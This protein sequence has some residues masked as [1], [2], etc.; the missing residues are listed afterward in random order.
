MGYF[1][2]H[3][4][5]CDIEIDFFGESD[6]CDTCRPFSKAY[7]ELKEKHHSI[8]FEDMC[9]KDFMTLMLH[10]VLAGEPLTEENK[11]NWIKLS[12]KN[13]S[14]VNPEYFRNAETFQKLQH[15][16]LYLA[17]AVCDLFK[18]NEKYMNRKEGNIN[19]LR[20]QLEE[21]IKYHN[22][23]DVKLGTNNQVKERLLRDVD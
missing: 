14:I 22:W 17:C 8:I 20:K 9:I 6:V 16:D 13:D 1:K 5:M 15:V 10:K 21:Y 11:E 4:D 19:Y 3:C 12:S 2:K 7:L 23:H 18:D